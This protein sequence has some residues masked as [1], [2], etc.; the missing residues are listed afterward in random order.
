ME[1]FF[2]GVQLYLRRHAYQNTQTEDLWACFE[3]VSGVPV[4]PV[5]VTWT[6]QTGYQLLEVGPDHLV[7]QKR[8]LAVG[9]EGK[10]EGSWVVPIRLK[11]PKGVDER[12]ML[13]SGDEAD[14]SEALQKILQVGVGKLLHF[15]GQ[16]LQKILH[17]SGSYL[18]S[19]TN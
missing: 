10:G 7:T 18:N 8:F 2:G 12:V 1:S 11:G 9:G 16:I 17:P 13:F 6:S 15:F 5:M 4:Q 3:E 14:T 19:T